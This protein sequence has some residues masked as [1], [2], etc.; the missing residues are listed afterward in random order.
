[1]PATNAPGLESVIGPA[2]AGLLK[3]SK[4]LM[5]TSVPGLAAA[6]I[7]HVASQGARTCYLTI[8]TDRQIHTLSNQTEND[9]GLKTAQKG[10]TNVGRALAA[11][12]DGVIRH[13]DSSSVPAG[14]PRPA[15][16]SGLAVAPQASAPSMAD[17]LRELA[18]LHQEGVLSDD[19]F[20]SAK[21]TLLGGL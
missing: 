17:R 12:G 16:D 2:V 7:A 4:H 11:A 9:F 14:V 5:K 21:A 20:A 3:G 19:E 6:G 18:A 15:L 13:I 1:M 10:H 8:V